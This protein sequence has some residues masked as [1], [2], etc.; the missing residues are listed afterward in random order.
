MVQG[1]D[2]ARVVTSGKN[3]CRFVVAA[4]AAA[5]VF[6]GFKRTWGDAGQRF[7]A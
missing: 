1:I 2:S 7:L 4:W 3:D 5:L 6:L